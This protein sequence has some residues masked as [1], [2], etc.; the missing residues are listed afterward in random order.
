[1][2]QGLASVLE[3]THPEVFVRFP[4][5]HSLGTPVSVHTVGIYHQLELFALALE[6]VHKLQGILEM[7]I[8]VTCAVGQLEHHRAVVGSRTTYRIRCHHPGN[9]IVLIAF[10]IGLGST[11]KTFGVVGVIQGPVIHSPAGNPVMKDIAVLEKQP[12][13]HRSAKGETLDPNLGGID[14]RQALQ[15]HS[16][17]HKVRDFGFGEAAVNLIKPFAAVVSRRTD[18]GNK[19]DDSILRP[20]LAFR[21]RDTPSVIYIRGIGTSVNFDVDGILFRRVEIQRIDYFPGYCKTA[22]ECKADVLGKCIK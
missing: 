20:P 13:C 3:I 14:I 6:F 19:M 18:I 15:P 2:P 16:P 1:M 21:G 8:V 10:G 12:G 4:G 11:H 9:S 5:M 17:L 7:H 22:G